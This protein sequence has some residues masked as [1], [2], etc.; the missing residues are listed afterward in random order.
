MVS[1]LVSAG[2]LVQATASEKENKVVDMLLSSA[3]PE[4]IL[5]GKLLG[6]GGA[7]LLQVG[8]WFGMVGLAGAGFA[9]G[10]E[11]LGVAIPWAA[12]G[13]GLIF[14]AAG[15]LF[16]GSLMLGTG[17]LGSTWRESQQI[18]MIWSLLAV[19]P[20]VFLQVLLEEPHGAVARSLTYVPF[21][22]PLAVVLRMSIAPDSM[23][24]WEV[25]LSLAILAAGTWASVTIGARLFRVGFLLTGAWPGLRQVV[26]QARLAPA[27]RRR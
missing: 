18:S 24:W 1:L 3:A 9:S 22:A 21:T 2:Y 15:Y 16:Y 17:S 11:R 5:G 23:P 19:V 6:L 25:G 27:R 14:F 26:R 12:A 10:L 13:V 4:E 20:V 7:G 8:V